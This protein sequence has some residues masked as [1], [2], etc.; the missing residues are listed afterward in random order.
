[1]TRND[2]IDT[3]SKRTG[4]DREQV[5]I[6]FESVIDTMR[7]SLITDEPVYIRGFGTFLNKRRA[8]KLCRNISKGTFMVKPLD[9]KPFMKPSKRFIKSVN[10]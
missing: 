9:L 7:K 3:V 4:I 8:E 5:A 1:M 10:K 6:V 2:V